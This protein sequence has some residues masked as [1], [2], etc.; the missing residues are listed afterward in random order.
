MLKI[1]GEIVITQDQ[2]RAMQRQIT[3]AKNYVCK[4]KYLSPFA[5]NLIM[6]RINNVRKTIRCETKEMDRIIGLA[7]NT[8]NLRSRYVKVIR[9]MVENMKEAM[10]VVPEE[11]Y[12]KRGVKIIGLLQRGL[13]PI[14]QE[15]YK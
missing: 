5:R 15:I 13:E 6:E 11:V 2:Y 9:N 1:N 4:S 3:F 8:E 7:F 10:L 14:L 12:R